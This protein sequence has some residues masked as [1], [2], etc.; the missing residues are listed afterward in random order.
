MGAPSHT[1]LPGPCSPP[2]GCRQTR[3][4]HPRLSHT[5]P[6]GLQATSL[7]SKVYQKARKLENFPPN[8][9]LL[10]CIFVS[11]P[12]SPPL[13]IKTYTRICPPKGGLKID[14]VL[15]QTHC[16]ASQNLDLSQ[17]DEA[18]LFQPLQTEDLGGTSKGQCGKDIRCTPSGFRRPSP[19]D[20]GPLPH[21][22]AWCFSVAMCMGGLPALTHSP[23]I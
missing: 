13:A 1:E 10:H 20:S 11:V 18:G 4:R 19:I 15:K 3:P 2:V 9:S 5:L 23:D 16:R 6:A 17:N 12:T 7:S 8:V 14:I 22:R 21:E